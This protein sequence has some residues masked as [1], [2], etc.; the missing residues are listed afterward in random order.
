MAA[1]ME[2]GRALE[3]ADDTLKSDKEIVLA[4]VNRAGSALKFE[5]AF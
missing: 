5:T 3:H 4:A 1:V 2:H